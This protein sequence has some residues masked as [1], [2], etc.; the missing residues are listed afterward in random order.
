M[1]FYDPIADMMD[2]I[3]GTVQISEPLLLG[4]DDPPLTM[5]IN[6]NDP[7]WDFPHLQH[8]EGGEQQAAGPSIIPFKLDS[9]DDTPA[10]GD[11]ADQRE[12]E[13]Q[14]FDDYL[15]KELSAMAGLALGEMRPFEQNEQDGTP[16]PESP[17]LGENLMSENMSD[18]G[19]GN[20]E[21]GDDEEGD[22]TEAPSANYSTKKGH[23]KTP[24]CG[25]ATPG[26]GRPFPTRPERFFTNEANVKNHFEVCAREHGNPQAAYWDDH[27]TIKYK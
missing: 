5:A 13:E 1:A 20:D 9:V 2:A 15:E 27:P 23:K 11:H 18:G 12:V 3:N 14:A 19:E 6:Q 8:G 24:L 10:E 25:M 16:R 7:S 21:E 26:T 22:D 17:T 4:D